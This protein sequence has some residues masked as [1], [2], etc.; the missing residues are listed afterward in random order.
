MTVDFKNYNKP[1]NLPPGFD[2]NGEIES[3]SFPITLRRENF[4]SDDEPL[5]YIKKFNYRFDFTYRNKINGTVFVYRGG[6]HIRYIRPFDV[7]KTS[8]HCNH[9]S[10]PMCQHFTDKGAFTQ[11][12]YRPADERGSLSPGKT[13]YR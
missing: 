13:K 7:S 12:F 10:M 5:D 6:F 2:I 11:F 8:S 1:G 4:L 3:G 9:F